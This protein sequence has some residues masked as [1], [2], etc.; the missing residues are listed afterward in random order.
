MQRY[1]GKSLPFGNASFTKENIKYLSAEQALADF[2]VLVQSLKE[3]YKINKVVSFG[4]RWL[5]HTQGTLVY[6]Y[7]NFD[8][9]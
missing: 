5:L 9:L 7:T 6:M 1:Y 4:G 8:C 2:A 3:Q